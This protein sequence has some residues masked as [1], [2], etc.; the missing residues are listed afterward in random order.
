MLSM[1][2]IYSPCFKCERRVIGCHG[3]CEDYAKYQNEIRMSADVF[4]K[5]ARDQ[6]TDNVI[7]GNMERRKR[8]REK[9]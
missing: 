8:Q 4:V 7:M 2:R 1:K 5:F 3:A 9:R 6:I